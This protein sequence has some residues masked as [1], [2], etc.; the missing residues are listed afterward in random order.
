MF[1]L[2]KIIC[3]TAATKYG[4]RVLPPNLF[5]QNA[6]HE[7]SA[8]AFAKCLLYMLFV[9]MNCYRKF[10]PNFGIYTSNNISAIIFFTRL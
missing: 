1:L 3:K 9:I 10:C 5:K 7:N 6:K 2:E 8:Y 4:N